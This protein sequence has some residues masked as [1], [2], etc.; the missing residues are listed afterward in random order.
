[1]NRIWIH[2]SLFLCLTIGDIRGQEIFVSPSIST[3]NDFG[4]EVLTGWAHDDVLLF[5]DKILKYS[6]ERYDSVMQLK[7]SKELDFKRGFTAIVSVE[8]VDTLFAVIYSYRH[9][10]SVYV[11]ADYFDQRAESVRQTTLFSTTKGL[12]LTAFKWAVSENKQRGVIFYSSGSKPLFAIPVDLQNPRMTRAIKLEF[13]EKNWKKH[14][15]GVVVNNRGVMAFVF[16][17]PKHWYSAKDKELN[18]FFVTPDGAVERVSFIPK[19]AKFLNIAL[20][21]DESHNRLIAAGSY[22]NKGDQAVGFWMLRLDYQNTGKDSLLYLPFSKELVRKLT[23]KRTS[24][25]KG[26]LQ[27][28]DIQLRTDGGVVLFGEVRKKYRRRP[29]LA[30][31]FDITGPGTSG[32]M[33]YYYEDIVA[34]SIHPNGLKHWEEVMYKHQYSQDDEAIF[35]SYVIM[36]NPAVLRILYNDEISGSN[37]VSEYLVS[38]EGVID[39]RTVINTTRQKLWLRWRDAYQTKY[40]EIIVPS[41]GY[42]TLSIVKIRF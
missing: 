6:V 14:F 20:K 15:E 24:K 21:V 9:E 37:T 30:R 38:S 1:M 31:N 12:D 3:R 35:S 11:A 33:D 27:V 28:T 32:W 2:I 8:K 10:G 4:Y 40:N 26:N 23:G 42:N 19:D 16:N 5:R 17:F 39:R 22:S 29:E 13:E 25:G 7:W 34:M 18:V 41:Q 36:S